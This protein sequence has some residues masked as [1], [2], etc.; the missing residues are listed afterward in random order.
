MYR[1]TDGV[2]L[3]GLSSNFTFYSNKSQIDKIKIIKVRIV[4]YNLI[5]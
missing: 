2:S 3:K 5:T 4:F 1:Y